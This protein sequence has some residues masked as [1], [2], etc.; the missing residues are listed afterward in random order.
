MPASLLIPVRSFRRNRGVFALPPTATLATPRSADVLPLKQ[1]ATDLRTS[2]TTARVICGAAGPATLRIRRD[3]KVAGRDAYRIDITRDGIDVAASADPGA[4]YAVQTLRE[5]LRIHGRKLPLCTISDRPDFPRR[6]VYLDCSRGKVP[7]LDTLK[8]LVERLAAWKLN[9][10]QIYVENVFTFAKHPAIG[11]G[12]SPFTPQEMIDLQ[13]HCRLHHVALVGSLASF[14]HMQRILCLPEYSRLGEMGGFRDLPGGTTLCPGDPGS[15][16]L[17]ED[18]FD[19]FLPLHEAVDFN[20]CC[21]ETW[22]L[23]KGRSRRRAGRVG[24][25]RVYLDFLLKL[26]RLCEKHGKRMNAWA[27]IVL[28]H[29]ELLGDLPRDIVMLNW[30]Y[31]AAGS[32]I[33]RT[34][35]I[36]DANLPCV[37]CPGTSG[38]QSHGSRMTNAVGNVARFAAEGRRRGVEGVLNTD[39][40]DGGHRNF[41]GV[42]LHGYAHGAAHA[43]NGRAVDDASF[44]RTFCFHAFGR[45]DGGLAR[46]IRTLG[47]TYLRTPGKLYHALVE[48]LVPGK[49]FCR[50]IPLGSPVRW[51]LQSAI[52]DAQPAGLR[53][54][55]SQLPDLR[56]EGGAEKL[57][58]FEALTLKELASAARM[59]ALAARRALTAKD[60][61]AGKTPRASVLRGLADETRRVASE[62]EKLWL[63]R[64]RPSR[65][66]DNLTLFRKAEQQCRKLAK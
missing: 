61:R 66:K 57:G 3:P 16:R 41:L 14:G 37:V 44:T 47:D 46:A 33:P 36:T 12:Y 40:G 30:E 55:A 58:R 56:F 10:F 27:D 2:G 22:E 49:D 51:P 59:D 63:A 6:G 1:L 52:D 29:P 28:E 23:G 45:R 50:T 19:E 64:S 43:W 21:D 5:L 13:D 54:I 42:S 7:T 15:I 35:E 53:R 11:R 26:R 38:W 60:I 34:R 24:V 39:W 18:L 62:F 4:Y 9:E 31:G 25:G 8:A 32:R 48:S 17:M 20:V 65:L